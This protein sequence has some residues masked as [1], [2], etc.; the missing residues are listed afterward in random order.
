MHNLSPLPPRGDCSYEGPRSG[1]VAVQSA[2]HGKALL[3]HS[4]P[5]SCSDKSSQLLWD[6]QPLLRAIEGL[7]CRRV[8]T[9]AQPSLCPFLAW[10]GLLPC[11]ATGS[12][13]WQVGE[14]QAKVC[15]VQ[16]GIQLVSQGIKHGADVIQNMLSRR[17]CGATSRENLDEMGQWVFS[18][19]LLFTMSQRQGLLPFPYR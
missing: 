2:V 14:S 18:N 12:E 3:P 1:A 10:H 5:Q 4:S 8:D 19:V 16:H 17:P 6:C 15:S 7:C 13:R 11:W 9:P